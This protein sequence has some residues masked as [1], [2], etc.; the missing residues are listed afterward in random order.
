MIAFKRVGLIGGFAF[1]Y[2]PIA[3]LVVYSFNASPT[4]TVWTGFSARWYGELL[5]NE[6]LRAA[7]WLSL[8]VAF[9]AACLAAILGTLAALVLARFGRVRL[10]WLFAAL[11][12]APLVMPE[13]V[14]AL[15]LLLWF[16]TLDDWIGWPDGRGFTTLV[17]GH[18]SFGVAY[19]AAI[20]QARLA[21][22]D[23]ALEDAA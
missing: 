14:S 21:L 22:L 15:T 8:Q 9:V 6:P 19:V 20:V 13:I 11:V 5:A 23:P 4:V 18:A 7:A 10:R 12:F 1:L 3:L 2:A 16:V 17:L